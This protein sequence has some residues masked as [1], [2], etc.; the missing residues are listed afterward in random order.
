MH[1]AGRQPDTTIRLTARETDVL[2]LIALGCSYADAGRRLKVSP[3]TIASHVKK[4]YRKL[5]VH[6]AAAAVG[7]ATQLG[8]I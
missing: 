3:H 7:L 8:L 6:S 4:A 2:R 5:G 1:R